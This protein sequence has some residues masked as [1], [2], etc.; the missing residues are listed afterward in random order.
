MLAEFVDQFGH[1][2]GFSVDG[3]DVGMEEVE[4]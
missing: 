1:R 3:D 2:R 4:E